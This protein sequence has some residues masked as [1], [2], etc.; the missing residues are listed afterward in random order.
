MVYIDGVVNHRG[1]EV[2]LVLVSPKSIKIEKSLIL[3]FS[4]TNNEARYEALLVGIIMVQKKGGKAVEI[5]SNS[6]LVVGQVQGELEV[7]DLRMQKY[8]SQVRHLQSR[9]ESFNLS[10]IPR[11]RN[12]HSDSLATL[13]TSSA[14]SL[15]R[16]ILVEDL[17]KPIEIE[18]NV[19]HIHQIRVSPS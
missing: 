5:F 6:R 3:G 16:V 4:T 7:R 13:A 17:C 9:F 12:I 18:G 14:R 8:L 10:Q 11:S 19:V 15:P 2:G 1:S